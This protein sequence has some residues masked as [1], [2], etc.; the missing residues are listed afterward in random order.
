SLN[1]GPPD[2]VDAHISAAQSQVLVRL[3]I[4][5]LWE[6]WRA[7][8]KYFLKRTLGREY[9]PLLDSHA[10][11]ALE[12]LQWYFGKPNEISVLRNSFAFH[13][14]EPSEIE[15]GFQ[16]AANSEQVA[17]EDWA[18]YFTQGL[19]NCCFFM[20]EVAIAQGM[21]EALREKDVLE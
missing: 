13:H 17:E 19:L 16:N 8:E 4:G 6:A 15:A 11:N 21:A 5:A 2:P 7:V 3:M 1:R 9:R 14:P 10:I 18:I 12:E 20:S